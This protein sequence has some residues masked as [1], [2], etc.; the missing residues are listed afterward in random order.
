[1]TVV[2]W[3]LKVSVPVPNGM[4]SV[5]LKAP[6]VAPNCVLYVTTCAAAELASPT[7]SASAAMAVLSVLFILVSKRKKY[8]GVARAAGGL[9]RTSGTAADCNSAA[10]WV[11]SDVGS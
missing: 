8:A 2:G 6:A 1:M 9:R 7:V 5:G 11:L 3:P 4:T 10:S